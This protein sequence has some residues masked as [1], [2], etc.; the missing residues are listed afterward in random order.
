MAKIVSDAVDQNGNKIFAVDPEGDAEVRA[1]TRDT[2]VDKDIVFK[3]NSVKNFSITVTES[4]DTLVGQL[5]SG[6]TYT[7]V[8]EAIDSGSQVNLLMNYHDATWVLTPVYIPQ[9]DSDNI[10]FN[11]CG[12]ASEDLDTLQLDIFI[13]PDNSVEI[14]HKTSNNGN[15]LKVV[16]SS[17]GEGVGY[18]NTELSTIIGENGYTSPLLANVSYENLYNAMYEDGTIVE[19]F[20]D[21]GDGKELFVG[22]GAFSITSDE[23]LSPIIFKF[24]ANNYEKDG[25][26]YVT[27]DSIVYHSFGAELILNTLEVGLHLDVATPEETL[28]YLN[29]TVPDLTEEEF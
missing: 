25:K 21:N 16:F 20:I 2:Y 24:P 28:A 18:D 15:N 7:A 6:T 4:N 29:I 22:Y 17:G 27:M 1:L 23:N 26:Q 12:I 11:L 14:W 5:D 10:G 8:K 13:K 9:D 3:I 19:G